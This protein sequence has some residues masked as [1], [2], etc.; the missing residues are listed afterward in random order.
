[1]IWAWIFI[2]LTFISKLHGY[3][4]GDFPEACESMR[5]RHGRG[6]A[7]SLPETSEPPYM[8]SY[9]LS[10]NVGDPIT[11]SLESKNGFMF[12]GF[13]LEARNLSLNG[14]GPPLGKFI[15]L[16][17]DQ[18]ILLKCGNSQDSAVGNAH[19]LAKRLVK[20]NWTADGEEQGIV[21]RAT[22][23][24]SYSKYWERVNVTVLRLTSTPE[25]QTTTATATT[26]AAT[27]AAAATTQIHTTK[28][29]ITTVQ[30]N[31]IPATHN[32]TNKTVIILLI[33]VASPLAEMSMQIPIII[34]AVHL[35]SS[36]CHHLHLTT[37]FCHDL[38]KKFRIAGSS[39]SVLFSLATLIL[40]LIY[41]SRDVIIGLVSV[42]LAISS[43]E[44]ILAVLPLGPSHELC[45]S[46]CRNQQLV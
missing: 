33:C 18:S 42:V 12:R 46:L 20:V 40:S 27:T 29:I 8:V 37:S 31:T 17:S 39:L 22:F 5:P 38:C 2:G 15:M 45:F 3:S 6:G 23:L 34:M 26:A 21:F 11:V 36:L 19:N 10:S 35:T 30:S 4:N 16:D 13:M 44:W 1:M 9:Q 28:D 14:D 43:M 24:E 7:E 41:N 32:T 25:P